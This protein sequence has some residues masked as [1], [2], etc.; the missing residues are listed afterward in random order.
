MTKTIFFLLT[1]FLFQDLAAQNLYP[2]KLDNCITEV[3]CLDCGDEQADVD[4]ELFDELLQLM[5]KKINTT[6]VSGKV[7]FQV[8]V[9]S[10]GNGCVLSHTD[11]SNSYITRKM[12]NFLNDFRGFIPAKT[13]GKIETRTSFDLSFQI[14][15]G[16]IKGSVER[17]DIKAFEHAMSKPTLP[18]IYN[19]S[20]TYTNPNLSNYNITTWSSESTG[21]SENRFD[22][23][24]IDTSGAIWL[25]SYEYALKFNGKKFSR[26]E[27]DI[28]NK[29]NYT[30]HGAIEADNNNVIWVFA[31]G[32]TC[33]YDGKEWIR[34]DSTEIGF[35]GGGYDILNQPT[36]KEVFFC[37]DS[38]LTILKDG[39]WNTINMNTVK[40]LP[41]NRVNFAQRDSQNRIWIGTFSGT[42]MI[43]ENG[44]AIN[45]NNTETVLKGKCITGMT[46]DESGNIYFSLFEFDRKIKGQ[47]NNDEGIAVRTVDGNYKQYTTD[48][49]GIPFNHTT[50]VAYDKNE[51]VLWIATDRAGL[52]RYD[53]KD[54]WENYHNENSAIPTSYISALAFDKDGV[55]YLATRSGLVKV[56]RK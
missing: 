25:T 45:F 14:S 20:Y 2:V 9:D 41:S 47:I 38:G 19:K 10:V 55:L 15:R 1:I 5:N 39:K 17:V 23:I 51:K 3:F 4:G 37:S 31:N 16:K 32:A 33:S 46:E 11:V 34:H 43:E 8:L 26:V 35:N 6:G 53:L 13:R 49:S 27:K 42:V 29:K 28:P 48:N 36:T 54:G 50:D 44:T 12:I 7:V 30:Y 52:V 24:T 40:E 22:H 21:I 18:Q 56:E